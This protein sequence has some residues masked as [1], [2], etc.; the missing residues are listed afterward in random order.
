MRRR[1]LNETARIL[2]IRAIG[3][4]ALMLLFLGTILSCEDETKDVVDVKFDPNTTYT[5]KATDVVSLISDSGVTRYRLKAK[6]WL[7]YGKAEDPYWY[8]PE[9]IYVEKFD[10]LFN[11]DAS[12]KADTAYYY[13]KRG[14]WELVGNVEIESLQGERFET[15]QLFWDQKK[16]QIYSSRYIRIEQEDKIVTGIGFESNQNMTHYKIFNSQGIFPVEEKA[17]PRDTLVVAVSDSTKRIG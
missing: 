5:M 13:D 8:F 3:K 1:F 6:D 14:L 16:E 10:T 4:I 2:G 11:T 17:T 7:V 15:S 12:I 9:G